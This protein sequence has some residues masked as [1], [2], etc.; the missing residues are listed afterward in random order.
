MKENVFFIFLHMAYLFSLISKSIKFLAHGIYL[1]FFVPD[2]YIY[3]EM[4]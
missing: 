3:P 2:D 4:A 1:F